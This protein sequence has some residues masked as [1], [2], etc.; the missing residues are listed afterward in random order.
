MKV[1]EAYVAGR[2][3]EGDKE[4]LSMQIK[5]VYEK[6]ADKIES[7]FSKQKIIGGIVPHAGYMFSAFQAVHYFEIISK[8]ETVPDT[9]VIINPNHRGLGPSIALDDNEF[10]ETP[11]GKVAIDM[12]FYSELGFEKDSSA[13]AFEHSGEVMVP[14]LQYFIKNSFKIVPI[15]L[16]KQT[17]ETAELLANS[18]FEANKKL[19]RNINII[20]S[21]D[22]SHYVDPDY[23]KQ[24]D[25]HAVN[26]I[27][28]LNAPGTY[29]AIKNNNISAC[30]Y[31]PI[32]SLIYYSHL[33][34]NSAKATI[35]KRGHS[36]EVIPSSE[37]VNYISFLFFDEN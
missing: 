12:E 21:S 24:Q 29:K 18:I 23:G 25:D 32:M 35:L 15:T 22:F 26:E 7:K 11:F 20:A 30:G 6:E 8:L 3:Y 36:G 17:P 5:Q 19:N 34:T 27:L 31:G 33:F 28:K 1:R 16:S 4:A 9:F 14:L 37:V 13:H 10:W 2:F